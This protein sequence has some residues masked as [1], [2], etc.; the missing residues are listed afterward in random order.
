MISVLVGF[1]LTTAAPG[2]AS[3]PWS[4]PAHRVICQV[5]WQ[6][7]SE[8]GRSFVQSVQG[9]DQES[10]SIFADSCT[11]ADDARRD[12]Y[13]A[14]Y[15]YHFINVDRGSD[16]I[17]W[18]RDCG[19]YDC[20][21]VAVIRYA[22]YL[23]TEPHGEREEQRRADALKFLGHFVGDL[24]QPMHAGYDDDLGGNLTTVR[25]GGSHTN[26]HSLWDRNLPRHAGLTTA[27]DGRALAQTITA[28]E[29][30]EWQNF[31]VFQWTEETYHWAV[32][33]YD[34]NP[35]DDLSAAYAA[36]ADDV[37]REQIAKAGARLAFLIEHARS[38]TLQFPTFP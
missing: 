7:L 14:T 16:V 1:A 22:Q 13:L 10:G 2:P 8:D 28:A 15:E 23:A 32:D 31:D 24:H 25:W 38:H 6:L 3:T 29:R 19:A 34:Y 33:A 17:D 35:E 27:A 11:W 18:D 36:W 37:V 5:A 20:V 26:L 9:L 4:F 12:R 21:T 30:A